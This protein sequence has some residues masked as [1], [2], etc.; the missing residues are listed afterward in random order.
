MV[1]A[2]EPP[3]LPGAAVAWCSQ[4][5]IAQL[6]ELCVN[7]P[8]SLRFAIFHGLSD[9]SYNVADIQHA[10]DVLGYQPQDGI[11]PLES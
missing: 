2:E 7:A 3:V 9:N 11:R 10:R 6:A 5:D 8:E 1:E 4:R